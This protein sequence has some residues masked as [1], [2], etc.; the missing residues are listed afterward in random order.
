MDT[1]CAHCKTLAGITSL[2][3]LLP[4]LPFP[5]PSSSK[6]TDIL[7]HSP[8]SC[9][10]GERSSQSTRPCTGSAALTSSCIA[11]SSQI[12]SIISQ[13]PNVFSPQPV[14][15][16]AERYQDPQGF[17]PVGYNHMSPHQRASPTKV[18]SPLYAGSP[19]AL[20]PHSPYRHAAL[21]HSPPDQVG[22]PRQ[23]ASSPRTFAVQNHAAPGYPPYSGTTQVAHS[24]PGHPRAENS[25]LVNGGSPPNAHLMQPHLVLS[26]TQAFSPVK[27]RRMRQGLSKQ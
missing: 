16:I 2:T 9:R 18:R 12:Y 13:T 10:R 21:Q 22:G 23:M 25:V 17:S 20:Q 8:K 19:G 7:L 6:R 11:K 5:A 15:T 24:S 3:D 1:S 27:T 26:P 14:K 4:E